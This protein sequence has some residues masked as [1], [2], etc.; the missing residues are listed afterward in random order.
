MTE[1]EIKIMK[2]PEMINENIYRLTTPY[3]DIYATVYIIKT[4]DGVL[5]FDAASYENDITDCVIP[6]LAELGIS[7]DSIKYVFIS[8]NHPD[9]SGALEY[10][11]RELPDICIISASPELKEKFSPNKFITLEEGSRVFDVLKVISIPGHTF[12]SRAILDTRTNTLISGDCLQA[13]GIC[14]SGLWA[15]N[16]RFPGEYLEAISALRNEN[17]QE[18]CAAHD[19]YPYGHRMC[20]AEIKGYLDACIEPLYRV[21]MLTLENPSLTDAQVAELYNSRPELP[22]IGAHVVEAVRNY[23]K[24]ICM[25]Q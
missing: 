10:L 13:H 1:T 9:H 16:I 18:I 7:A 20:S 3:K 17:I 2:T 11:V 5:L 23:P 12:D 14:G 25:P 4:P 24:D 21:R 19:Y 22:K 8:H 6:A 15:A